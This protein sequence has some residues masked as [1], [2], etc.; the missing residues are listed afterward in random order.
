MI[1]TISDS[2]KTKFKEQV[3]TDKFGKI[4]IQDVTPIEITQDTDLIDFSIEDGVYDVSNGTL[5]GNAISKK[6][7][8]SFIYNS[9]YSFDNKEVEVKVGTGYLVDEEFTEE[10]MSF[11]NFIVNRCDVD[12]I[13]NKVSIEAYDYMI[14]LNKEYQDSI[15]YPCTIS[16]LIVDICGQCEVEYEVVSFTNSDF[17]IENNQF[18]GK[19]TCRQILQAIASI[20]G[21][22]FRVGFDNKLKLITYSASETP[23]ET[24][25]ADEYIGLK[26]LGDF[27]NI[28][29]VVVKDSTI[30][31]ELVSQQDDEDIA[32]NGINEL[33]V[34]DNPFAYTQEKRET[35]LTGLFS[36]IKFY[37]YTPIEMEYYCFP[38][39]E[40]GDR[41]SF[42]DTDNTTRNTVILNSKITYSGGIYSTISSPLIT[43][44]ETKYRFTSTTSKALK[45]T[46]IIL[47]KANSDI[48]LINQ[49]I[50]ENS[51][52]ISTIELELS[53]I[54]SSVKQIGGN[55][56]QVNSVG[57]GGTDYEQSET[58]TIISLTTEDL[59][60]TTQSGR[61]IQ[62]TD[63]WFEF[64]SS[65]LIIGNIYTVS[66]KY[67]NTEYN[68][69]LIKLINNTE[70]ILV[71]TTEAKTLEHVEYTFVANTEIVELYISSGS[72]T[73]LITDYYLQTGDIATNWQPA[74][75]EVQSTTLTIYYNGVEVRSEDTETISKITS[76]GFMVTDLNGNI[77]ITANK[78]KAI[79]KNLTVNGYIEQ[80]DWKRYVQSINGFDVLLEVYE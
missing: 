55:N 10:Y 74:P 29:K 68:D 37:N 1:T 4:T 14:K 26:F 41:I 16:D 46:Q 71:N 60:T 8:A 13:N 65:S 78:D 44:T 52:N 49:Q 67:S 59:R 36:S 50:E 45:N 30:D 54:N 40:A 3:S 7:T 15:N 20:C 53:S 6:L 25:T 22:N 75:G 17:L 73:T 38:Y 76:A 9:E 62:I 5:I 28:N 47:D 70:T 43:L 61:A 72:G 2:F 33:S 64:K 19:E 27:K 32:L 79:I 57:A 77:V 63:K 51:E 48:S 24:I 31:G 23:L 39:L 34:V 69:C 35:I 58:G 42:T 21:G 12:T 18:V 11:G 56:K 66:F 80:G